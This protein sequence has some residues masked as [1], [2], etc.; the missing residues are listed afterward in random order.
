[1]RLIC[2]TGVR[3]MYERTKPCLYKKKKRTKPCHAKVKRSPSAVG[4]VGVM[5]TI[6]GW[7]SFGVDAT[8][9]YS[10]HSLFPQLQLTL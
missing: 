8:L 2:E 5:I 3:A 9:R 4:Q 6:D 1:M 7:D 10:F